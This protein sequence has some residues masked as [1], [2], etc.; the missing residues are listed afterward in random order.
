[1]GKKHKLN[2]ARGQQVSMISDFRLGTLRKANRCRR[3]LGAE[4]PAQ[5]AEAHR[6]EVADLCLR[7]PP[8]ISA[9]PEVCPGRGHTPEPASNSVHP[10]TGP[11]R[12]E[13][14]GQVLGSRVLVPVQATARLKPGEL[15]RPRACLTIR[16]VI[17]AGVD[18]AGKPSPQVAPTRIPEKGAQR[19][20]FFVFCVPAALPP[21]TQ[22][23]KTRRR[24]GQA[25]AQEEP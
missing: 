16:P 2:V 7:R 14:G 9:R 22:H 1:M 21:C 25:G 8:F 17:L 20:L 18:A 4:V 23:A 24:L 12:R 6:D 3:R 19:F 13:R 15:T 11:R 5:L 10:A